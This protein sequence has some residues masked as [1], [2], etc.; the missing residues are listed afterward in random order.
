MSKFNHS[1]E[2]IEGVKQPGDN[3]DFGWAGVQAT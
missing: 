2:A 1:G 3:A